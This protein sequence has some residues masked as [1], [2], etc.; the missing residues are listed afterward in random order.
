[1]KSAVDGD[2]DEEGACERATREELPREGATGMVTPVAGVFDNA[3]R[4]PSPGRH[5]ARGR[6]QVKNVAKELSS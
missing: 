2:D 5:R 4:L 6:P 1:M 3:N